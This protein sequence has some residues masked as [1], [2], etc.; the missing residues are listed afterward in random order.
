M[1]TPGK[2]WET[3]FSADNL[4]VTFKKNVGDYAFYECTRLTSVT[5]AEGVTA[6]SNSAFYGCSS[7]TDITV[8]M[9][10]PNY[11]SHDGILYNKAK[12]EIIYIPQNLRGNVTIPVGV[13][14]INNFAFRSCPNLV[15]ITV[16]ANNPNYAS[17]GGI[18]YNKA[19]TT[20]ILAPCGIGGVTIPI[21]VTTIFD[22]AFSRCVRL[23][24]ITIPANVT[25]IGAGA[26]AS[27]NNLT[28]IMV[29][30]GNP[31][32]AS[33]GGILFDKAKI[34]LKAF[35]SASGSVSIPASVTSIGNA[36]F[37]DCTGLTSITIPDSVTSIGNDAFNGCKGLT[38]ITIPASVTSIGRNAFNNC[39]VLTSV[40]FAVGSAIT[41][42]KFDAL[43][44][45][46]GRDNLRRAYLAGG[47]GTYTRDAKRRSVWTKQ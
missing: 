33:E 6:I 15:S 5:I 7:L 37:N 31:N 42:A 4:I 22:F 16:D 40:T 30:P 25:T 38:S 27:C 20:L 29:D 8:D 21:S 43:A 14:F 44:F 1:T 34:M 26:F 24:S 35:P 18:L 45:P 2:N 23:T 10:N 11:A 13:M 32:Y 19:K 12:T 3:I 17:E 36:A 47:A 9:S 39:H 28:N 41:S 46:F